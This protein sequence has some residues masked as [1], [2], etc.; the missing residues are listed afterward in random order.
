MLKESKWLTLCGGNG[1]EGKVRHDGRKRDTERVP[2]FTKSVGRVVS[3]VQ[4]GSFDYV[5]VRELLF[6]S[7]PTLSFAPL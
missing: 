1:W 5:A 2:K 4:S 6:Q 3:N 7:N